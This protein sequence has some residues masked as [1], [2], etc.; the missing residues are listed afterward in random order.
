M[1]TIARF[2]VAGRRW[3][4][5]G[6]V[7]LASVL[8]TGTGEAEPKY[9]L[10]QGKGYTVCETFLKNLNAF[11]RSDPPMICQ[12][13]IHPS[14][15][16]FRWP[17]WEDLDLQSNLPLIY[18]AESLLPMFTKVGT[19]APEFEEWKRQFEERLKADGSN[20]RLRKTRLA[21]NERGPE[22]IIAYEPDPGHCERLLKLRSPA[23]N[24]MHL[25]VMRDRPDAP[26][27]AINGNGSWFRQ[28]ILIYKSQAFLLWSANDYEQVQDDVQLIWSIRLHTVASSRKYD[29]NNPAVPTFDEYVGMPRCTIH[30]DQ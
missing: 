8:L 10:V 15:K 1:T 26:L 28:H 20:P 3:L 9:R 7:V 22:T 25:F 14:S 21:L 17:V 24:G 19:K 2:I 12:Q 30:V 11:P 18:A 13:K 27:E 16:G 5:H 6:V 29:P 23:A 4:P